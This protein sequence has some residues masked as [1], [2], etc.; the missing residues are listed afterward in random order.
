M[1][2]LKLSY[3][4]EFNIEA[5]KNVIVYMVEK[6]PVLHSS[7]HS[8]PVEPYWEIDDYTVDDILTVIDTDDIDAAADEFLIGVIP[9]DNNV[10][11]KVN[12]FRNGK[13]S[14]LAI[15]VNHMCMD[16]GD[17]K[18]F[19]AT[20]CE[21]YN[22][23]VSGEAT[24]LNMKTGTRSFTEVYTK[25]EGEDL[26]KAKNLY[27]N[28][29]GIEDKNQFPWTEGSDADVNRII[30][31]KISADN[32]LKMKAVCKKLNITV[33]DAV[34]AMAARSLYDIGGFD[35]KSSMTISCAI[36]LRKHIVEGAA[37]S[38]LT[39]HTAW[40]ACQTQE[41]GE[42]INDTIIEIIRATKKHKRD[43]FM[44]L[45]SL[46]L[47]KLAYTI[48]PQSIAEFAIKLGYT[49][50]LIAI[51]NIGVL[52]EKKLTFNGTKLVDGFMSG[53]VK[54]KPYFLMSLTT[55]LNEVTFSTA[56]RG[57]EGDVK[58]A[59]KFFDLM[60]QN[61]AEFNKL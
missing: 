35:V 52:D 23:L 54:Y 9:Y 17:L 49:N 39:N 5:L 30:R 59:N 8:N 29:S 22:K 14:V 18:Y 61:L 16:G 50:P 57:N 24:A 43:K 31:R 48:F 32:F 60:E 25:F 1:V 42:T 10:Q 56:I 41:K 13:N 34:V 37:H 2:H 36:D 19:I 33:N 12:V 27:K 6:A 55:L 45:H 44:G 7:F 47:L 40:M 28:I 15:R 3:E 46:P 51:S 38:G 21:N 58:M 20:F 4:G 53:A 26:K 11:I